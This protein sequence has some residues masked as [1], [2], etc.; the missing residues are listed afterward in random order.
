MGFA[1]RAVLAANLPYMNV[2]KPGEKAT[3]IATTPTEFLKLRMVS[4]MACTK[5]IEGYSRNDWANSRT[6]AQIQADKLTIWGWFYARNIPVYAWTSIPGTTSTDSWATVGNQTTVAGESVRLTLNAWIRDGAPIDAT[7][8]AAVVVG[9]SSN[10]LRIGAATHPV[11]A[12]WELADTVESARDSGKWK[13]SYTA[14]GTH[15]NATGHAAM[16]AGVVT[17]NL[18]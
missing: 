13:A 18:A 17:A 7:T 1:Q 14:D 15:P 2:A 6:L 3:D 5:V 11:A 12:Y 4:T 8:R 10:V 9:T 16:A